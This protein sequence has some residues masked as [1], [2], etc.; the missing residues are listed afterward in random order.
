M[1]EISESLAD[2][3]EKRSSRAKNIKIAV[4]GLASIGL[5]AA[6]WSLVNAALYAHQPMWSWIWAVV[7]M[8]LW[9][10]TTCF[11]VMVNT[12]RW[13]TGF[14]NLA[15]LA[16]YVI[17][18]PRNIYVFA[19]GAIFYLLS[20]LF[21]KRILSEEKNQM[22]FSV[23]RTISSGLIIAIYAFLIAIG[24]NLYYNT[25][26]DFKRNPQK[27]YDRIGESVAKSIPFL[28]ENSGGVNLNQSLDDYLTNKADSTELQA[29]PPAEKNQIIAAARDQFLNQFGIDAKGNEPLADVISRIIDDKSKEVLGRF[30][31]FFP[32]IFTLVIIGLLRTFAFI[33][34]WLT[35]FFAWFFFRILLALK[36]FRIGKAHVEV[37]QL[38]V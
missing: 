14:I 25:N 4:L 13:L 32:L 21:A 36:F 12:H 9:I 6:T 30:E 34:N 29:A 5:V 31:K 16:L 11:F 27:F 37:D 22:H 17:L 1:S 33:F 15:N 18:L 19:G 24:F 20:F 38:E 23:R 8:M 28:S 10:I 3:G 26:E 7:A 35:V 2:A